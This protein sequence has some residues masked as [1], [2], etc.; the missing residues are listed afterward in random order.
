MIYLNA[1]VVSGLGED[2]FWTWFNREF[3]SSTFEVPKKLEDH[4]I[5]LRYSTLGFLPIAGKQI[6]LCWEL[7]PEMKRV[8][9]SCQWDNVIEKVYQTARYSTYRTV[10]SDFSIKD[11]ENF[12]SVDVIPIGVDTDIFIPLAEKNSLREK[13]GIPK[14]KKVGFWIGTLHP[15]KGFADLLQY[16]SLNPDIY[17]IVVWKWEMEA[18]YLEGASNFVKVPQ[19]TIAE[20]I[21]TADFSLFTSKLKPFYMAE[22]EILACNIPIIIANDTKREFSIGRNPREVVF[23]KGWD[24][25][26]VKSTWEKYLV[27][28]GVQW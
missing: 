27:D 24:R 9:C 23:D 18:G 11:Y 3:P 19:N 13:Y 26:T 21:N 25:V 6:A 22:W 2:T 8:F 16:A 10:A 5:L 15:M 4:D 20:L 12:G 28:R 14:N 7:Y 1:E 17:W